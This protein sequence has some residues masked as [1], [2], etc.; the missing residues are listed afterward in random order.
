MTR[1]LAPLALAFSIVT[2]DAG[3]QTHFGTGCAGASGVTPTLAVSGV[4]KSG[5]NWTLQV[6]AP[7]GIGLGYLAIGFSNTSASTFGGLPLPL[8]LGGFFGDPLWSGCSLNVD[9]SYALAPYSFDPNNNGGLA[10]FTFPGFD[11]GTVHMQAVNID[12]DFTTRVAGVSQG[13]AVRRTAPAGMVAIEPGTFQ[14]GSSGPNVAPY[15]HAASEQ[16]VHLVTISHPFWM[17]AREVTQAEY[18]RL[19][20]TNPSF[21]VGPKWPVDSVSWYE[22]RAYC[23]ALTVEATLAGDVPVGYEYRLPT[24][25]EWEY[26]CRAGTTTEFNLGPELFCGEAAFYYS[27]HSVSV[28]SGVVDPADVGSYAPNAWGLYDMHGN[29][30]EWCLDAFASYSSTPVTDPFVAAGPNRVYRG[31]SWLS[32]SSDCRSAARAARSPY[33]KTTHTGFRVVLAPILV[34][35]FPP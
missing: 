35:V 28:C 5:Q 24:E 33:N 13:L 12:A 31:G 14:M 25:A 30:F 19:M 20:G 8:D 11:F 6:T 29:A 34:P 10:T 27:L 1:I 22:A 16:L 2:T 15:F 7:G 23:A 17:A 18:W 9:P 4:V 3:A 21:N 32:A 26:A